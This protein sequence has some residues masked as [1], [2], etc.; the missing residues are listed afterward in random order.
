MG[1]LHI[2]LLPAVVTYNS[3]TKQWETKKLSQKEGMKFQLISD[4]ICK[5]DILKQ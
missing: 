1:S 5:T 2:F 3:K 4:V